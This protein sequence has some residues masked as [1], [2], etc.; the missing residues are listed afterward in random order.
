MSSR[1]GSLALWTHP[2][3]YAGPANLLNRP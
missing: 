3:N 2:A 1:V